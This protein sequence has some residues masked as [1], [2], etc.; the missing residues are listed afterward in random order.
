M[1]LIGVS[2]FVLRKEQGAIP[3]FGLGTIL[4]FATVAILAYSGW[5]GGEL[6]YRHGVGVMARGADS[7]PDDPTPVRQGL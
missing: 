7:L 1:L 4:S 5:L 2:N 3:I 6:S